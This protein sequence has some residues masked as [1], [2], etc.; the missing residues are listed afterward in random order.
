MS[1]KLEEVWIAN[2]PVLL[3]TYISQYAPLLAKKLVES[4]QTNATIAI[5]LVNT[6]V[7]EGLKILK[8]V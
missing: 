3:F 5:D 7:G 8:P 6:L 2:Q 1:T 4:A